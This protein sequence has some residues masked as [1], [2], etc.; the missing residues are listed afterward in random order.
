M[1]LSARDSIKIKY[2]VLEDSNIAKVEIFT[3][4]GLTKLGD[5]MTEKQ[6]LRPLLQALHQVGSLYY[7]ASDTTVQQYKMDLDYQTGDGLLRFR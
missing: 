5:I 1:D 4:D 2:T 6:R 7:P 3:A